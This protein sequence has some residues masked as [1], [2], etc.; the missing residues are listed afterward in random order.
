MET[1]PESR[2]TCDAVCRKMIF[3]SLHSTG[4]P[5]GT[6]STNSHVSLETGQSVQ[7]MERQ[8]FAK[9]TSVVLSD[10]NCLIEK[11]KSKTAM[12]LCSFS[13][14]DDA[15]A[16]RWSSG[17]HGV[18][19]SRQTSPPAHSRVHATHQ[20]TACPDMPVSE[21]T[22]KHDASGQE[23]CVFSSFSLHT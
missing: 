8:A 23:R 21:L 19:A 4:R 13:K 14:S 11:E 22:P 9:R 7:F 12:N 3:M 10:A 5:N 16:H 18:I 15:L 20:R 2:K 6:H 1:F 17:F